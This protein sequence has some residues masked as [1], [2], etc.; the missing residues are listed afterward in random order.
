MV[1]LQQTVEIPA[2]HRLFIEVPE[3]IP[4]GTAALRLE[5]IKPPVKPKKNRDWRALYGL[6]KSDGREVDRFLERSHDDTVL[7]D[8]L[9]SGLSVQ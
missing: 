5:W 1:M 2:D 4:A 3:E 7:E 8:E 6:F 9:A